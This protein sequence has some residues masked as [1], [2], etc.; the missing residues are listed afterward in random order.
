MRDMVRGPFMWL[1]H[2]RTRKGFSCL[3]SL[4]LW[5]AFLGWLRS[6]SPQHGHHTPGQF[7]NIMQVWHRFWPREY[8]PTPASAVGLKVLWRSQI[9]LHAKPSDDLLWSFLLAFHIWC[10]NY[11]SWFLQFSEESR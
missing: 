10:T 8:R 11:P 2:A 1:L 3:L 7:M 4:L 6:F 9:P 5:L